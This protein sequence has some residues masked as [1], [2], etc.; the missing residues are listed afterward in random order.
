MRNTERDQL[1]VKIAAM[2]NVR[3]ERGATPAEAATAAAKVAELLEK[4]G[5]SRAEA[6]AAGEPAVGVTSSQASTDR[7]Q[8]PV[9][10]HDLATGVSVACHCRALRV[11]F[12]DGSATSM[13]FFGVDPDPTVAAWLYD[14]CVRS[15]DVAAVDAGRKSR[16]RGQRL[17]L[18]NASFRESAAWR[19]AKRLEALG[20]GPAG[21][22][23]VESRQSLIEQ[24]IAR[25]HGDVPAAKT[26]PMKGGD[27]LGDLAGLQF[28][29]SL[30]IDRRGLAA[31]ERNQALPAEQLLLAGPK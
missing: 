20:R 30:D 10:M 31:N 6:E 26:P 18:H 16:L 3:T 19:I 17:R 29:E 8:P 12:A 23:L 21:R 1:L 9:W 7:R 4:Y 25:Q 11:T 27:L 14:Y 15:V 2:L 22:G 28:G 24:Y 13:E 5:L